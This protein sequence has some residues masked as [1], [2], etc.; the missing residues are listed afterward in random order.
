M[1]GDPSLPTLEAVLEL[2][3][4]GVTKRKTGPRVVKATIYTYTVLFEPA[5]EGGY[6][7][8]VPLL[9]G[10]ITEGDTLDEART[11][12][13]EAIAGYIKVLRKHGER[14]PVERAARLGRAVTER[15]AVTLQ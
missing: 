15:I 3:V 11:R 14:V 1:T 2:E 7:V 8:T 4:I 5:V 12:V 13:R 6:T 9:P 10:V